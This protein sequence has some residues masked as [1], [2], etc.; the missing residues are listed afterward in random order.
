MNSEHM[1]SDRPSSERASLLLEEL[2]LEEKCAQLVGIW[3]WELITPDGG[4]A[5]GA[6]HLRQAP[7]GHV[8]GLSADDATKQAELVGA[9]QRILVEHTRAGIPALIHAEALNGFVVGGHCVFPT[10]TGL[11][12]TW[13][14][15][16]V[17][18]M[19]AVIRSQMLHA[20]VRHA[21][22]PVLDV[23]V[24]PRWG[25]VHETYGEDP[26]LVAA[27]GVSFVRGIRGDH[28]R[29]GIVA[30]AKHFLAYGLPESGLNLSA[31][32]LGSRRLRDTYAYPFE[33]AIQLADLR[34]V[35]NS[36]AD[37]DSVPVGASR[38]LLTELLRNTLGFQGFVTSDYT[39]T[40]H[41]VQRQKVAADAA[42]A[43]R[44]ALTAGLDVELP[45]EFA[46]GSVLAEEVRKGTVAIEDVDV[47]VERV[48]RAKFD[49]GLFENPYP[50]EQIDLDATNCVGDDLSRELARRAVVLLT[51]DGVLP[52]QAGTRLAVVGPHAAA[53]TYQFPTYT[54]PAYREMVTRM[55][56][57]ELGNAVGVDVA[58]ATWHAALFPR[59]DVEELVRRRHGAT[60]LADE[61]VAHGNVVGVATGAP[62]TGG[63]DAEE[64]RRAEEAAAHADV[65]IL[66]LGGA[67][68]WFNGPRTEGEGSDSVDIALP[69]GQVAL[70][71]AMAALGKPLVVVLFQGRGYAL[72]PAVLD[73]SAVVV[74][75]F[76]GPHGPR[77]VGEVLLGEV[78]PSGKLPYSIPRHSGQVPIYHYMRN[79][80]GQHQALP[81]SVDHH[82]LDLPATPAF[83]FGH[84]LSYTEFELDDLRH[85]TVVQVDGSLRVS[86]R[87]R[88]T[89][90]RAGDVVVQ[91]YAQMRST[92]VTRPSQQLVGFA[93]AAL[94]PGAAAVVKF[95]VEASQ[96]G[97]TGIDGHFSVAASRSSLFVGFHSTDRALSGEFEIVGDALR[98][99]S[100]QRAFLSTSEVVDV[101]T[102]SQAG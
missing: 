50:R 87:V 39:T 59:E 93:R 72:P 100:A 4:H 51:N 79:G 101:S 42:E 81:P 1:R 68:L 23:A 43:G 70:A 2:T 95:Q 37:V 75:P 25:R 3:P 85:D 30:T 27:M 12:S 96:L 8:S 7:P 89:G 41:L 31:A 48:L 57:G 83:A 35:M 5:S 84:G 60:A 55:S 77:A 32:E 44:L 71:K 6:E 64:L 10:P 74:A 34:S 28:L 62:L 29:D 82:Y 14:P 102:A 20:G 63:P 13:S 90:T 94:D 91:L 22:S 97:C 9:V 65:L 73:A 38:A 53:A 19:S 11:A 78:N 15:E 36:Y 99:S 86:T 21:L 88:N 49:L 52:L 56:Q 33:A 76:G 80:S 69:P 18:K 46:F 66:A 47:A 54:Y 61:L 16:L 24:D 98:L 67:S 40:Q 58:N 26:Y 92:G 17:E 45:T